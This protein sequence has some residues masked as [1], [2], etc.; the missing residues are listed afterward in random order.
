ML[1]V[2]GQ[3]IHLLIYKDTLSP[4]I[5]SKQIFKSEKEIQQFL[6]DTKQKLISHGYL[7][8]SVDSIQ[9]KQD[10]IFAWFHTGKKYSITNAVVSTEK[11]KK[12]NE[13][14]SVYDMDVAKE[15]LTRNLENNGYPFA[16]VSSDSIELTDSLLSYKLNIDKGKLIKIDSFINHIF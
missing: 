6:K 15:E 11:R 1:P 16:K 4:K 8:A 13:I 3:N 2:Y 9:K 14:T 7:E 5:K 12:K 10:S